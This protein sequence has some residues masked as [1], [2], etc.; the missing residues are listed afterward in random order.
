MLTK[1]C[2]KFC[3]FCTAFE[4]K[5]ANW[6]GLTCETTSQNWASIS[7]QALNCCVVNFSKCGR[8]LD[9]KTYDTF[10]VLFIMKKFG[11]FSI[12]LNNFRK[13]F[14]RT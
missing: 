2:L 13:A 8:K 11:T 10:L 6:G 7:D 4:Q 5:L 14:T 1:A 3:T 12:K 9:Q